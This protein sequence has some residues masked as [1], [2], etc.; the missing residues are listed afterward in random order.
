VARSSLEQARASLEQAQQAYDRV[1][2]RPEIGLLPQSAQLQQ[3]TIG[4]QTAQ[5][6][7]RIASRGASSAQLAAGRAQVAQ[8]QAALDKLKRGASATQADVAQAAVDQAQIGLE[9][10]QRRLDNAR[11]VA[12]W[13]GVVSVANLVQGA[14][15]AP[16]ATV[17]RLSDTSRFHINVQVDEADVARLADQQ[18]VSIILDALADQAISGRVST[19]APNAS[20]DSA[21]V[22]TYQVTIL[23]DPGAA[24]L[25]TGMSA[26]ASIVS[27]SRRN[28]LLIP[29]RAV[30]IQRET[31][32]TF[33]E[34]LESGTPQKVEVQLGVQ[35]EQQSEVRDGLADGDQ[36]IIR[37]AS[38]LQQQL[39]Q[40]GGF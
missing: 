40:L 37:Q 36:I 5:A 11:L 2:D 14:V 19:I 21:G 15:A 17:V 26:T 10:A 34:R 31:G 18:P 32:K 28:V 12:P 3:A 29:N 35:D 20:T 6:Q 27:S 1:K 13:D 38:S 24:P 33:V 23:I 39:Q 30:Q 9:Q 8:A 22:V 7:Y 4:Y 25:R 16:S